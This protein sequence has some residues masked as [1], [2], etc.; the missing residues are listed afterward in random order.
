MISTFSLAAL[1]VVAFNAHASLNARA[2]VA[3]PVDS[4]SSAAWAADEFFY[5]DARKVGLDARLAP[6]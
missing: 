6:G 2:T 3:V 5:G 1:R 4:R